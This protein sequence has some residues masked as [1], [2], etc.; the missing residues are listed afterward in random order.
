MPRPYT[1]ACYYFPNYHVDARNEAAHGEG[2]T[3]WE[4]VRRAEPRFPGHQQPRVPAW[5]YT[6]EADPAQMAQKIAAA[7]DHGIDAFIF[8]W[9]WYDDGPYLQRGLDEGLIVTFHSTKI[10]NFTTCKPV[11]YSGKNNSGL[12]FQRIVI[13]M[14]IRP[15]AVDAFDGGCAVD[16]NLFHH[17]LDAVA[18]DVLRVD[19][20]GK[21]EIIQIQNI[22]RQK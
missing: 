16:R 17:A 10:A 7:A 4:L 22:R 14:F 11:I 21:P 5:G 15:I 20:D 13:Q 9:Y 12:A 19:E 1:V 2:W 8:D 18:R 3:E 6:D